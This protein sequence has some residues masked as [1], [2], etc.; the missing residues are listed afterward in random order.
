MKSGIGSGMSVFTPVALPGVSLL[1]MATAPSL[2]R[3]STSSREGRV[4][5][6]VHVQ[7]KTPGLSRTPKSR[8]QF[9]LQVQQV[10]P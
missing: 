8:E 9:S 4:G 10:S 1:T 5:S 2:H 3:G 7:G 6:S